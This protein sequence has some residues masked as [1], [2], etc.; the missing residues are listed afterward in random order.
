ME[1]K[2][3]GNTSQSPGGR[4]D[5]EDSSRAHN[6]HK[7]VAMGI[8]NY[9]PFAKKQL[10]L[11][12]LYSLALQ[13]AFDR[14][15]ASADAVKEFVRSQADTTVQ[16]TTLIQQVTVQT[17]TIGTL[18]KSPPIPT[19][20]AS[21]HRSLQDESESDSDSDE[22][23]DILADGT[24]RSCV[25]EPVARKPDTQTVPIEVSSI[26]RTMVPSAYVP[27]AVGPNQQDYL[28]SL[29]DARRPLPNGIQ[30]RILEV[31][32]DIRLPPP[33]IPNL[34]VSSAATPQVPNRRIKTKVRPPKTKVKKNNMYPHYRIEWN[35]TL[36]T[37]RLVTADAILE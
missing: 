14:A 32:L 21:P 12:P 16:S 8:L 2:Q 35:D 6:Q 23:C 31:M 11:E 17:T 3:V 13:H 1:Q 37:R 18:K 24:L 15:V 25:N 7:N 30:A 28:D 26:M 34:K 27:R 19:V 10:E 29:R 33:A 36:G 5:H 22:D 9:D 4:I 20:K